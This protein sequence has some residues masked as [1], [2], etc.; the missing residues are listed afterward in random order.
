[1]FGK[2]YK[3]GTA[4][5][6]FVLG[7]DGKNYYSRQSWAD[8]SFRSKIQEGARV[9]FQTREWQGK[10]QA[11]AVRSAEAEAPAKK[12]LPDEHRDQ[13]LVLL[14]AILEERREP[15]EE[16]LKK[17][18]AVWLVN[19]QGH[20]LTDEQ[21]CSNCARHMRSYRRRF[22]GLFV[23]SFGGN[24]PA[25]ILCERCRQRLF[26]LFPGSKAEFKP[27][28]DFLEK[29][30]IRPNGRGW[31]TVALAASSHRRE[32]SRRLAKPVFRGSEK[33]RRRNEEQR[34]RLSRRWREKTA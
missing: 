4:G 2:I 3:T 12:F 6:F 17:L 7:D 14:N 31:N 34:Q 25:V 5:F 16:E 24:Q 23:L 9:E 8:A 13:R 32:N 27:L 10:P 28:Y 30:G 22:E 19:P 18:F 15:T 1:M 21:D 29:S 20:L 33:A 26:R 11:F